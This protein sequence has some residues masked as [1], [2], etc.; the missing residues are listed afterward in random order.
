M[1][2]RSK[3][4]VYR[5]TVTEQKNGKPQRRRG[6]FYWASY[7]GNDSR[8]LRHVLKLPNGNRI[9]DK[10]VARS[11]LDKI[12]NRLE[13]EAVGLVDQSIEAAVMP[14]RQAV[15]RLIRN[16]R[17]ESVTRKH[18]SRTL[19]CLR[20][21]VERGGMTRM[22]DFTAENIVQAFA[23]LDRD[24]LLPRSVNV[25]RQCAYTFAEWATEL[26]RPL[27]TKNPIT[28]RSVKRRN[29]AADTRKVRRALTE[30]EIRRLLAVAGPRRLFYAM[31]FWTGLRVGD[32]AALEWRDL[33][34]DRGW[35][36]L[37]AATTESRRA[38]EL[39]LH[40]DLVQMLQDAKPKDVAPTDRVFR[41]VPR[42]ATFK[43]RCFTIRK[44]DGTQEFRYQK[45]DLDRA[46]IAFADAQGR[47]MDLHS[48]RTTYG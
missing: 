40:R 19:L 24:R 5:P 26:D 9:T 34:L 32:P 30:P 46:R 44:K 10:D 6:K 23:S 39:P 47:T 14:V 13:R 37:R 16:L 7:V 22:A 45:G 27:L 12:I 11:E 38:D 28:K 18:V 41:T 8:P 43:G 3:G 4:S 20:R 33:D 1:V 15:A 48:L 29:E 17:C 35:L 2:R 31:Q 36:R 42:L 21:L 25:H